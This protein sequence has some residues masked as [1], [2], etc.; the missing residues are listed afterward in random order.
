MAIRHWEKD[1][2]R[3]TVTING[4]PFMVKDFEVNPASN[5][6]YEPIEKKIVERGQIILLGPRRAREIKFSCEFI[7]LTREAYRYVRDLDGA[8][9]TVCSPHLDGC[10]KGFATVDVKFKPSEGGYFDYDKKD[11]FGVGE[12]AFTV[13]ETAEPLDDVQIKEEEEKAEA[14]KPAEQTQTTAPKGE[15][16]EYKPSCAFCMKYDGYKYIWYVVGWEMVCKH[17][18]GRLTRQISSRVPEAQLH[19]TK[20]GSNYCGVCGRE[21]VW[22]RKRAEKYR[23]TNT[24]K[25]VPKK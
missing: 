12:V 13:K 20:C 5:T 17:C 11:H 23:I 4:V 14:A 18:G 24:S 19:C 10:M 6:G 15:S 7:E 9:V 8:I 1:K 2:D 21:K 3:A 25:P 16:G 22:D